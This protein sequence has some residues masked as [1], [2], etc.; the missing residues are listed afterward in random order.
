MDKDKSLISLEGARALARVGQH[1]GLIDKVLS[2]RE[3]A[4]LMPKTVV[5]V[6]EIIT[7]RY[8]I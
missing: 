6:F 1:I 4:F 8:K 2:A 7:E 5:L 3:D